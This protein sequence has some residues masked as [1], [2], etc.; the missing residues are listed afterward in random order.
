MWMVPF[1]NFFRPPWLCLRNLHVM[2]QS[3]L[4]T[5]KRLLKSY[6][7][8]EHLPLACFYVTQKNPS[9]TSR[10]NGSTPGLLQLCFLNSFDLFWVFHPLSKRHQLRLRHKIDRMLLS[11]P[12]GWDAKACKSTTFWRLPRLSGVKLRNQPLGLQVCH[13]S[14][15]VSSCFVMFGSKLKTVITDAKCQP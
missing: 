6:C 12:H 9:A 3:D 7:I 10:R 1:N 8:N 13:L 11:F 14:R 2:S 4:Q 15:P 5:W